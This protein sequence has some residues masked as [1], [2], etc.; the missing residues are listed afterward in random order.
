[1]DNGGLPEAIRS[2][3]KCSILLLNN[4]RPIDTTVV[5]D[6]CNVP[7]VVKQNPLALLGPPALG[8]PERDAALYDYFGVFLQLGDAT[9]KTIGFDFTNN[10]LFE[11]HLIY[12]LFCEATNLTAQGKPAVVHKTY[13]TIKN[14]HW[15]IKAGTEVRTS[16]FAGHNML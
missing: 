16:S 13:T 9:L 15:G 4:I 3:A 1:M 12:D 11:T 7:D 10:Q 5:G 2:G 6:W 14:K 8:F